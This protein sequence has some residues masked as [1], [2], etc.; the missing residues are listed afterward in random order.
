MPYP[1]KIDPESLGGHALAVITDKGW[2]N[3]SLR[4]VAA[5][6]HVAPNALYR[7]V[8]GKAGLVVAAGAEAARRMQE[9]ITDLDP[10]ADP[11][12][13]LVAMAERYV[14][15]AA[16]HPGAYDAFVHAKP[17][18]DDPA[19]AAWNSLW[20]SVLEIVAAV[21]PQATE[22]AGFA[23]WGMLHGRIDLTRGPTSSVDPAVGVADAV[24]ALVAGFQSAGQLESPLPR[25]A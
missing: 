5:S 13:R 23:L 11:L 9:A 25:R 15:F 14:R 16:D 2:D 12:D 8:P 17:S 7:Y 4:D 18:P 6:L 21:V 22:A 10:A 1:Q 20:V 24:R 19:I 3:W